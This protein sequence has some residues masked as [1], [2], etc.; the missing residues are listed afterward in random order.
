MTS[1]STD[2][3]DNSTDA[4]GRTLRWGVLGT[5]GIND[6]VLPAM[7]ASRYGRVTAIAS[8]SQAKA[9][10]Q[11]HRFGIATAHEGYERLLADPEVDAVYVPLPNFL[12]KPWVLAAIAAGKHVLC[13]KPMTLTASDA[14]ELRSAA[15]A[16]GVVLAEGFMYGHHPRYDRIRAI[17][18]SGEIGPVRG[19]SAT[20]TFDASDEVDI[21]A[22]AGNPGGG[23]VYDVGCYLTHVARHL[24]AAEPTAVT[25]SA[26]WSAA[27]G[28]IDM[29]T[30][31]L[32]EFGDVALLLQCGMWTADKD[33]VEVLGT[34]GR[35]EVPSAFFCAPGQEGFEVHVGDEHRTEVVPAPNQYA[36]QADDLAAAVLHGTPLR[37]PAADAAANATVLEALLRS[38]RTRTR[39]PLDA[40][41]RPPAGHDTAPAGPKPLTAQRPA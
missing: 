8:R 25:A 20:F 6:V 1:D 41:S 24:L 28:D 32:V 9:D 38:A 31:A 2:S 11:A 22:F 40:T 26:Q 7:Q 12:H 17:L 13:E 29:M 21:T 37:Y 15:A 18:R 33:T 4:V 27:H 16:A 23:A 10:E 36:L 3:L 35:I 14:D 39:V 5:A 30:A 19:I 34:T